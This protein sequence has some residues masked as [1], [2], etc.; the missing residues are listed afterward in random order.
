M[1]SIVH[2]YTQSWEKGIHRIID[3]KTCGFKHLYPFPSEEDLNKFYR[4]KYYSEIKPQDYKELSVEEVEE[5]TDNVMLNQS[6]SK[7]YEKVEKSI[8]CKSDT[9]LTMIDVGCGNDLLSLYFQRKGWKSI[10]IEPSKEASNYLKQFGLQVI[11]KPVDNIKEFPK[12]NLKFINIQF[13]LE[14]LANPRGFLK[15][16][17]KALEPGGILRVCVP[18]DFSEGQ[19]AYKEYFNEDY[20]WV[21]YPDHIN[22]F[23]FESLELLLKEHGFKEVYKISNFPLEFLLQSGLNY[24]AEPAYQRMVSKIVNCFE[25]SF[26]DTGREVKLEELYEK[27]AEIGLGRSIYMYAQKPL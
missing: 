10:A 1:S 2:E 17:Y 12:E 15:K 4:E 6:Y 25:S 13:V 14:H 27:L 16:A 8:D 21:T 7:I 26:R 19:L 22:Y 9:E 23:T 18:N 5:K 11:D 3:C 24:Y 20:H